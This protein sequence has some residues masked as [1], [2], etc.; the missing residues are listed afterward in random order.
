MTF[1][2]ECASTSTDARESAVPSVL[3][4]GTKITPV[5]PDDTVVGQCRATF[6]GPVDET[7]T[8]SGSNRVMDWVEA[9]VSAA[10]P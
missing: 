8:K 9:N 7:F 6:D 10:G 1:D 3:S 5:N 2:M 4:A